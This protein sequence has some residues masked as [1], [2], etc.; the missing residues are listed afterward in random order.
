[1]RFSAVEHEVRNRHAIHVTEGKKRYFIL[2][3]YK[4]KNSLPHKSITI[5][6][7]HI[8]SPNEVPRTAAAGYSELNIVTETKRL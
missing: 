7:I 8:F 3:K 2:C 5:C 6:Y 4:K 1:M